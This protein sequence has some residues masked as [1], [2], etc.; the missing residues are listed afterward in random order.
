MHNFSENCIL[1]GLKRQTEADTEE[2]HCF[3]LHNSLKARKR[4]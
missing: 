3:P 4:R 2:K 1:I